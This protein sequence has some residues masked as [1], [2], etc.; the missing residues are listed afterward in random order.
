MVVDTDSDA[1]MVV[2]TDSD[3]ET[4]VGTDSGTGVDEVVLIVST[5]AVSCA[6]TAPRGENT[7]AMQ[8]AISVLRGNIL[9]VMIF[10]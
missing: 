6:N 10:L 8:M 1:E 2:D 3:T 9:K 5:V 7:A 4:V